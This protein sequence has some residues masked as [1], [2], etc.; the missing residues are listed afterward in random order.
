MKL[1]EEIIKSEMDI[2][3]SHSKP[4][5]R[6]RYIGDDLLSDRVEEL[7]A[8][9]AEA[10]GKLNTLLSFDLIK[11]NAELKR[12]L[13]NL[14]TAASNFLNDLSRRVKRDG[15]YYPDKG[16]MEYLGNGKALP[17]GCGVLYS[18]EEALTNDNG[19]TTKE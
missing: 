1:S 9:L 10:N 6:Y 11:E 2:S 19:D 4:I 8:E 17:V 3:T 13:V 12:Q 15:E 7:E 18:L 16:V 14:H 5:R